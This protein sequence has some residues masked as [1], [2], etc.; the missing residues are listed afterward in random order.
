MSFNYEQ[1]AAFAQQGGT[2]YFFVLFLAVL[3]Y[4]IRPRNKA[5]FDRAAEMPLRED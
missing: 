3:F 5:R 1:I 2:I 4:A